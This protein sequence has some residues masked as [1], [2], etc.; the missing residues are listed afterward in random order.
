MVPLLHP[1][2]W[3]LSLART[4][5]LVS[6]S[7]SHTV[8][9]SPRDGYSENYKSLV[10][11]HGILC[12]IGFA[13]LLPGGA[14]L[15]RYLRTFRPWW[16]TGHWVAQLG[17]A[18]PIV[19]I[20]VVLGFLAA[21]EYGEIGKDDH[22]TW[23]VVIL[24]L[25]V[26]QCGLGAI[27]H[28]FKPKNARRRPPQNYLHAVLGLV[29][30]AL[31]MYQIRTGYADEWPKLTPLGRLPNGVDTLWIVWCI[32]IVIAYAAGMLFIRRQFQQEAAARLTNGISSTQMGS[33]YKMEDTEGQERS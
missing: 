10:I 3:F 24:A 8:S 20:G 13:V 23:G 2:F 12:V 6:A 5:S 25:Y 11:A 19:I 28:Y 32:L 30:L 4:I 29:I 22:K 1:F 14:I 9:L 27:I 7:E 31:G 18:G 21:D 33:A 16:Y 26:L 15:A 17:I